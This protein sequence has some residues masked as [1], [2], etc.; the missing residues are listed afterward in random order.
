MIINIQIN[1]INDHHQHNNIHAN[2]HYQRQ[3]QAVQVL[4][5]FQRE[6]LLGPAEPTPIV[7]AS[8]CV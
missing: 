1:I 3:S 2:Y 5:C 8:Q 6:C 4:K 7:T